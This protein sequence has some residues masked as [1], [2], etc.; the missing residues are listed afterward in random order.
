MTNGLMT[1]DLLTSLH[2]DAL[3]T[4]SGLSG[5]VHFRHFRHFRHFNS[6]HDLFQEFPEIT[7]SGEDRQPHGDPQEHHPDVVEINV[8]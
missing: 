4:L 1:N 7:G 6:D 5:T 8:G 3:I 2:K